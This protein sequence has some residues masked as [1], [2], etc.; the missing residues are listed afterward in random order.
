MNTAT[1]PTDLLVIQ[2]MYDLILWAVPCIEKFPRSHRF[3]LGDVM[4]RGLYEILDDLIRAKYAREKLDLLREINVKLE[5]LRYQVRIAR[6]LKVM[7]VKSYKHCSDLVNEVGRL[8][9]GWIKQQ[10]RR[11]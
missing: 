7:S 11:K 8:V 4:Q 5:I 10:G 6:D 9:G 3:L 2:K 1:P